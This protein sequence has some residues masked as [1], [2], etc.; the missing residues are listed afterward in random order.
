MSEFRQK[1]AAVFDRLASFFSMQDYLLLWLRFWV[2]HI[3]YASG[4]T[5]VAG[6]FLELSDSAVTLF[7]YEYGLPFLPPELAAK[8]AV[9]G[10]TF[11]PLLLVAGLAS[12]LSALG[13]MGMTLVIQI[14]VYPTHFIEHGTWFVALLPIL[15]L[16]G[17]K[18]SLDHLLFRPRETK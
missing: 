10:E 2:A 8:L 9:Y 11:L 7:E 17:G 13:L 12:R 14:F 16:G 6:G 18:I 1:L 15:M 5:K 3:F 4:R